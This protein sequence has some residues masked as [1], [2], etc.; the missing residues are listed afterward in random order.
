MKYAYEHWW[1]F[2]PF[3]KPYLSQGIGHLFSLDFWFTFGLAIIP[4][5]IVNIA[6]YKLLASVECALTGKDLRNYMNFNREQEV[7]SV[8]IFSWL[9]LF[10]ANNT[11]FSQGVYHLSPWLFTG[12]MHVLHV[13][14][15]GGVF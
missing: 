14:T 15:L 1:Y 12:F 6:I 4:L 8:I 10:L 7:F 3:G 9:L 5:M 11:E 13:T 2:Q